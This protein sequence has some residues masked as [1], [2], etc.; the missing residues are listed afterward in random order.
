VTTAGLNISANTPTEWTLESG[1]PGWGWG[2]GIVFQ[3]EGD[4]KTNN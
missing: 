2:W 3:F 4:F 1:Q